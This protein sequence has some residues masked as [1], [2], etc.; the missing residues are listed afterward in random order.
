MA[1]TASS[2]RFAAIHLA[3]P[4]PRFGRRPNRL[5]GPEGPLGSTPV[6]GPWAENIGFDRFLPRTAA[7]WTLR[8]ERLRDQAAAVYHLQRS[9]HF[10][11]GLFG[12]A[13][14]MG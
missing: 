12:G 5:Y 1:Q 4:A 14:Y 10:P 2:C 9:G 11:K 3:A 13:P 6:K 8:A 7:I